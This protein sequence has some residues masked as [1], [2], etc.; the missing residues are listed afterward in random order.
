V[1][2]GGGE[3]GGEVGFFFVG[4]RVFDMYICIVFLSIDVL[5]S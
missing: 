3:G 4:I 5:S 1:R 2:G